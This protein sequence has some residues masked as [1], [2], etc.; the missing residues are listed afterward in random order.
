MI[1]NGTRIRNSDQNMNLVF[2]KW[3]SPTDKNGSLLPY[4]YVSS[5]VKGS[6]HP[7]F[8]SHTFY[9]ILFNVQFIFCLNYATLYSDQKIILYEMVPSKNTYKSKSWRWMTALFVI[10]PSSGSILK[11]PCACDGCTWTISYET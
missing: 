4:M 11:S 5:F 10:L 3:N 6:A 2:S 9:N 8:M 7:L 1:K